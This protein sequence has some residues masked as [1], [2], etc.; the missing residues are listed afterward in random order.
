[1]D[2]LNERLAR[3]GRAIA[4]VNGPDNDA[5]ADARRRWGRSRRH[6]RARRWTLVVAPALVI[7]VTVIA[8]IVS[9]STS[10]DVPSLTFT[11]GDAPGARGQWIAARD[12][13]QLHFSDG[14]RIEV[15]RNAKV[16][17]AAIDRR[18][19]TIDL[20][21]GAL[22]ADVAHRDVSAWQFRTGP[23]TV[24]VKGTRFDAAWDS[25]RE[26]FTL[27]MMQGTVE[28]TG[29]LLPA[30]VTVSSGQSLVANVG[31][32]RFE[33]R[34]VRTADTTTPSAN[35]TGGENQSVTGPATGSS[36]VDPAVV[37]PTSAT[38]KAPVP[39][40]TGQPTTTTPHSAAD[41][42][43]RSTTAA[44]RV[45]KADQ[46]PGTSATTATVAATP[47]RTEKWRELLAAR[48]YSSAIAAAEQRGFDA[49]VADATSAELYAL[50]DAARYAGRPARARDALIA[51]RA[52][53]GEQGNTAFLLG[54]IAADEGEVGTAIE[55]FDRYLR[56][57]PGGPLAETATGRL[58]ELYRPRDASRARKLAERY[59]AAY[60]D[61][62]YAALARTLV[63][64]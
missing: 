30:P 46:P 47:A 10:D 6:P 39:S 12:P 63:E 60:P 51:V 35:A 59:L 9:R 20:E 23:Y 18:G 43:A 19:G 48:A 61:G 3:L 4:D 17:V 27:E 16:R 54:R 36:T 22:H 58:I 50:S 14:S 37:A 34:S 40:T 15:A 45:T 41:S 53:F 42:V 49:V 57:Q 24:V 7:G 55:W 52:R 28:V 56:E 33:I 5:I 8:V 29:P 38:A 44:P 64:H 2:P 13:V 25:S 62:P 1:M 21:Q 31:E 32:Q 26:R 11:V